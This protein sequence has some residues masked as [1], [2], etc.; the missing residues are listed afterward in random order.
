MPTY[1]ETSVDTQMAPG[2]GDVGPHYT[3]RHDRTP[4]PVRTWVRTCMRL[5]VSQSCPIFPN[6]FSI[7]I[8]VDHDH[9]TT[10]DHTLQLVSRTR[11]QDTTA[12]H[13]RAVGLTTCLTVR[14]ADWTTS[15]PRLKVQ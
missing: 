5:S 1:C 3:E 13:V 6:T 7:Y 12:R 4:T 11:I 9:G 10:H 8:C 15:T 14:H 2:D